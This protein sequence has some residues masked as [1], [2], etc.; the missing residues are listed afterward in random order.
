MK[1]FFI[2]WTGQAFS[3]FGS[4]IVQFALIWHL[5]KETG[6]ATVLA[7]AAIL[8]ML[9][10]LLFM[11]LIGAWVDRWN[12]KHIMV[13]SDLVIALATLGLAGLFWIDVVEVWHI[14]VFAFF[15]ALGGAF[16]HP[17]MLATT[18]LLVPVRHLVRVNSLNQTLMGAITI[19]SPPIGV[20]LIELFPM[21]GV[22]L[23]DVVT[24]LIAVACLVPVA[25]PQ[26]KRLYPDG[27]T[28]VITD[29]REGFRFILGWKGLVISISGIAIINFFFTPL[30][31]L[32][33]ILITTHFNG[34]LAE[35][36][37]AQSIFGIGMVSGGL[38]M[39]VWGGF[40]K[41]IITRI[42][43]MSI[44]TVAV[45]GIGFTPGSLFIM[46]AA[47]SLLL[48]LGLPIT[49][50]PMVAIYQTVV[51]REMHG[52][53]FTLL[54]WFRGVLGPLGLA[55]AG[56][57][58]DAIGVQAW[59]IVSGFVLF[60]VVL[61]YVLTPAVMNLEYYKIKLSDLPPDVLPE[62]SS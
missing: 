38:I 23:V 53:L 30:F 28:S 54:E 13:V 31:S 47:F 12:R 60:A 1:K 42:F 43:G 62:K 22:L 4:S 14:Y 24:A 37:W 29:I 59:Y 17:A 16:H 10:G 20:L 50:A 48:G 18:P 21:Q 32:N 57:V 39:S 5:T 19:I 46:F 26:P 44:I 11:P 61:V 52:R 27:K 9:P 36:G 7:T 15:R 6:S 41:R 33:P 8:T 3:I 45:L 49:N 35:I 56:P 25:I 51:P 55:I 2:I 58:S 34:G 40:K